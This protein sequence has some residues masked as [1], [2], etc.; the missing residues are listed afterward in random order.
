MYTNH[1]SPENNIG[2]RNVPQPTKRVLVGD[3]DESVA[4]TARARRRR[5][6]VRQ[7]RA[8][9]KCVEALGRIIITGP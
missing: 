5:V 4:S 1:L 6:A 7:T 8:G 3:A 9:F 2:V